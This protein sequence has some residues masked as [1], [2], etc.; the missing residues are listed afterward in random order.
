M[1]L[2]VTKSLQRIRWW[3]YT[4]ENLLWLMNEDVY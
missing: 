4:P 2:C 1:C 3:M